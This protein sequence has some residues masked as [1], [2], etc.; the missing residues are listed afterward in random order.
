MAMKIKIECDIE[1][2][3]DY[4]IVPEKYKRKKESSNKSGFNKRRIVI[5]DETV[6]DSRWINDIISA[7]SSGDSERIQENH[8]ML[9]LY[10]SL[11]YLRND[12]AEYYM[13]EDELKKE[14]RSNDLIQILN[15]YLLKNDYKIRYSYNATN[16]L[17]RN[18]AK[19]L[20]AD[21]CIIAK[22]YLKRIK[23]QTK[24]N[25]I[26]EY[27]KN[28]TKINSIKNR[29]RA[30]VL[31]QEN[32][33]KICKKL[34]VS[35]SA[36]TCLFFYAEKDNSRFFIKDKEIKQL[37]SI[38]REKQASALLHDKENYL[39]DLASEKDYLMLPFEEVPTLSKYM[40]DNKVDVKFMKSLTDFCIRVLEELESK[41]IIH[42]DIRPENIFVYKNKEVVDFRLIDFGCSIYK[43]KE[44]L[45]NNSIFKLDFET[46]GVNYR[47]GVRTWDDA[48]SCYVML[49]R[50]LDDCN[51]EGKELLNK[52]SR[53]IGVLYY[54]EYNRM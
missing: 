48:G 2:N 32:G 33:F 25:T 54:T 47:A 34:Q 8:K 52:I 5:I 1:L 53:R 13:I 12:T 22:Y 45:L 18:N 41:R 31:K 38:K 20:N 36:S 26:K 10:Y 46:A 50:M 11:L 43:N 3:T 39:H 28:V 35:H 44:N 19:A 29:D 16:Y 14:F 15:D 21:K 23:S 51:I 49:K 7:Y 24:K 27:K 6:I 40:L 4:Y 30:I 37:D 42:R 9:R 17:N